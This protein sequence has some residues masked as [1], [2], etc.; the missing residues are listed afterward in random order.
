MGT[1]PVY[2]KH[3]DDVIDDN[4]YDDDD[5]H[6]PVTN[7]L[8]SVSILDTEREAFI[9]AMA[10]E[11]IEKHCPDF[12]KRVSL[13]RVLSTD[14]PLTIASVIIKMYR[15]QSDIDYIIY[16][17]RY[18]LVSGRQYQDYGTLS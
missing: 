12:M 10:A 14:L 18:I 13:L 4:K 5:Y 1:H 17:L 6:L 7:A 15:P 9:D 8:C 2:D 16:C 11:L 3:D